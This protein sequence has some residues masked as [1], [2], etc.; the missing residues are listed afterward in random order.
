MSATLHHR[1]LI[2]GALLCSMLLLG[3]VTNVGHQRPVASA[4]P[5]PEQSFPE[6]VVAESAASETG[7][8]RASV[9]EPERA[10]EAQG[11][12]RAGEFLARYHGD[13]W[14]ELEARIRATGLVDLDTPYRFQPWEEV[15]GEFQAA[16]AMKAALRAAI[17]QS[18]LHWPEVLTPEFVAAEYAP[19]KQLRRLEQSD[20]AEL[21]A[22]VEAK[23][24]A[25]AALGDDYASQVD[26]HVQERWARG[27]GLV[28][29]FTT[30]GLAQVR[31][32]HSQ[33]HA[34]HGWAVTITLTWEDYPD[35]LE[36]DQQLETLRDERDLL[37]LAHLST[38]V[39]R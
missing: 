37:V 3:L 2:G 28:A 9:P 33:S 8:G 4:G 15:Q 22:V 24:A 6:S 36:L 27:Q 23:N 5:L 7:G 13:R 31:G 21:E 25:I 35:M 34:A 14:P 17:M 12:P 26:R 1:G 11:L 10:P 30:V 39:R 20:L 32:F 18:K 16:I 19:G 38:R 29:P